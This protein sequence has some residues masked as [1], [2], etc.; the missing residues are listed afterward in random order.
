MTKRIALKA[1]LIF[2]VAPILFMTCASDHIP[3][4]NGLIAAPSNLEGGALSDS[5]I[6]VNWLDNSVNELGFDIY[7]AGT[8]W[9]RVGNVAQNVTYWI[10]YGL[11]DST[12]YRYYVEA[13]GAT[14]NS[15]HSNV[16]SVYTH[17]IGLP[18]EAPNNP[19]PFNGIDTTVTQIQLSWECS[20]PDTDALTYDLYY[21]PATIPPL[22]AAN[23]TEPTYLIPQVI[24]DTVL[25]WQVVAKDGHHHETTSAIWFFRNVNN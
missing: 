17:A 25:H 22:R 14:R 2:I 7:R 9:E 1:I 18:P 23:L 8:T 19:L 3:N 11:T 10:D 21:G 12:M 24:A 6:I 5:R 15:D 16:I 20:D 13:I 4:N